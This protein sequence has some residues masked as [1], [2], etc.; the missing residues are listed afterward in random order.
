VNVSENVHTECGIIKTEEFVLHVTTLVKPVII[1]VLLELVIL[2][3]KVP[4]YI[5]DIVE[6]AQK[7]TMVMTLTESVTT[8][9]T[10][11]PNVHLPP[12]VL[13]VHSV[14]SCI[15]TDVDVSDLVMKDGSVMN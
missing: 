12:V 1:T 13:N 2:A 4:T 14:C 8:V 9:L 15:K 10:N 3:K 5:S 6:N 7:D 11:V